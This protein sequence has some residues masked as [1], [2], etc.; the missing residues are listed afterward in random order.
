MALRI[1]RRGAFISCSA[2]PT[3]RNTKPLP[4]TDSKSEETEDTP[5]EA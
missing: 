1:G 2:F 5:I 4:K 3:C